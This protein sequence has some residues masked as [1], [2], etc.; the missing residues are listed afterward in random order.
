L[1][2]LIK[3]LDLRLVRESTWESA[4]RN[5]RNFKRILA[6]QAAVT[7]LGLKEYIIS[8]LEKSTSQLQQDLVAAWIFLNT[9]P[10]ETR[11]YFVEFGATDGVN[12]SNTL[13]LE[14]E[15][16]FAGILAEPARVWHKSLK[17]NRKALLDF[18]CV[19]SDS[20]NYL[21]F[22]E[23]SHHE[24]STIYSFKSGDHLSMER[25]SGKL[26]AVETVTLLN[27]LF[28]HSA[29]KLIHYFS[30]DTEGSEF[31]ILK[32]FNF[33]RWRFDF[34]SVEHN[35]MENRSKIQKLME[36]NNYQQILPELSIHD[37]WYIHRTLNVAKLFEIP[38]HQE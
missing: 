11:G 3:W 27:L 33:E 1:N 16:N 13:F 6:W 34:V 7:P 21:D 10:Q 5:L 37:D 31:E 28:E 18:R 25:R 22:W 17:Q 2:N 4:Q 24:Y 20:G 8:N 30:I 19:A 38:E 35:Y 36:D 15:L 23:A 9:H 26:Y 29:P 12:L 32:D 14:T